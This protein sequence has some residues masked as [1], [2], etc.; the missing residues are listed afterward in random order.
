MV[1][2]W[3]PAAADFKVAN[4]KDYVKPKK[5]KD[6]EEDANKEKKRPNILQRDNPFRRPFAKE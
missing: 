5:K 3:K 2:P 4:L 1:E 6:D